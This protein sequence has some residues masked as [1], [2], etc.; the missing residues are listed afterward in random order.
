MLN[1]Y[2]FFVGNCYWGIGFDL[3]IFRS[4]LDMIFF[5]IVNVVLIRLVMRVLKYYLRDYW[6]S[7][8]FLELK[9]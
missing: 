2:L 4:D 9:L 7:I 8:K 6:F 1:W 5:D 3:F